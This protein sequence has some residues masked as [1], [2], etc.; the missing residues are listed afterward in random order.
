MITTNVTAAGATTFFVTA[1]DPAGPWSDPTTVAVNG[2]DPDLAWD[3]AGNCWVHFSGLG[4][5]ARCRID[6]TDGRVLAGPERTWSGTGLQYPESPHLFQRD[7][8]W[9][10]MIAEGGTQQGHCVSIARGPSPVGPWESAPSNPILT[11]RSTDRPIQ[12]TGHAD[13]VQA[14][15][16]SWWMVLLGVRPAR[17]SGLPRAG[18][19]DLSDPGRLGR[20][21]A[22]S[23]RGGIGNGRPPPWPGGAR[24]R[25][26][27]RRLRLARVGAALGR[28]QAVARDGGVTRGAPGLARHPRRRVDARHA[29]ARVRRSSPTG[30]VVPGQGADRGRPR[31]RSGRDRPDGR[32]GPLRRGRQ[33]Q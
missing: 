21:V 26:R 32:D 10:L 24:G 14:T 17:L 33:P 8:T 6:P 13:L 15:D 18:P 22:G 25:G 16:G 31:H 29:G 4:G 19:R 9:Y 1:E 2:I 23:A 30:P 28:D 7:G 3:D 27:S 5:I 20:R 11:N 12:N